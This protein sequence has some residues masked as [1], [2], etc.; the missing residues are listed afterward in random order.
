MMRAPVEPRGNGRFILP[1]REF[2]PAYLRTFE[3]GRLKEKV[4]EAI[5]LLGSCRVCPRN[6]GVDR[7][8]NKTGVCRSGRSAY[9]ANAFPHF[10]EEDC[11]RGWRGSGTI[12][13]AG[14]NLRCVFCQNHEISQRCA[15]QEMRPEQ[16]AALMLDLQAR[17]CH[18]I[19]FV[20]PEHVVPQVL[21][22]LL[23]AIEQGL[24]VPLVY[25]TSSYDGIESIRLMDGVVD[26][27]MPDFKLW[28]SKHSRKY[29]GAGDYP[30][31]ALTVINEMHRQV[32]ELCVDEKGLA[33]KGLLVRH[34][35]MPNL[36]DDTCEIMRWLATELS[37]D[38]YVNVMDQYFP[39][40]KVTGNPRYGE[41]NQAL[42][43]SEFRE[44]LQ[45]AVDAGLWRIDS[46][47]TA[48]LEGLRAS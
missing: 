29:L 2:V 9:V 11:L 32:G 28:N 6:C 40:W 13:F 18:N 3:S 47:A 46:V 20:T 48:E 27:Y 19:N 7:L 5:E 12:F 25:N 39:A 35:V 1:R 10:G 38:T 42:V 16:L 31:A 8:A 30:Q 24:R 21:E 23:P 14:C 43:R 26:I 44:A 37:R 41:I 22:A 15:G 45:C 17:G 33:L 4:E 36:L 34:L